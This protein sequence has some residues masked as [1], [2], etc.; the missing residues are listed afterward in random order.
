M[1]LFLVTWN[2]SQ[3]KIV[4]L[5]PQTKYSIGNASYIEGKDNAEWEHLF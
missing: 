5:N 4:R 3:T 2:D 1:T